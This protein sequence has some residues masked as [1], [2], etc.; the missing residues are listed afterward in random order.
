[1]FVLEYGADRRRQVRR[2]GLPV[3]RLEK[4]LR[5]LHLGPGDVLS[6]SP[7][8]AA[9]IPFAGSMPTILGD[10]S[11]GTPIAG[12]KGVV[13]VQPFTLSLSV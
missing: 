7:A 8:Q 10:D 3:A 11:N 9:S 5:C 12:L 6:V 2:W 13:A 1:M 4:L